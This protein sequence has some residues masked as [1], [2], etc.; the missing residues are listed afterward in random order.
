VKQVTTPSLSE[1][2]KRA[3]DNL[4]RG[5]TSQVTDYE[6]RF[7]I[8]KDAYDG[9]LV[10]LIRQ[11]FNPK[12]AWETAEEFF[13]KD[14]VRFAGVDGT[15]YS[16]P[17]FDLVIFFGGSYASTGT[18]TF[19]E[20][21]E[22]H[23]EYDSKT[24]GQN[25]G[26]SSV[27]PI[28]V[29]EI[30]D[31]DH[32]FAAQEQ[33]AEVD[34]SKPATDW[35]IASNSLIA[36]A[37]MTFSEFYLAYKL[38][39]DPT[40]NFRVLLMDR[41]LSTERASLL[42]ETRKTEF[43]DAKSALI[44][45]V[46]GGRQVDKNDLAIARQHVCNGQLGLPAPRAD[47]LRYAIINLAREKGTVTEVEV[48]E[49]F[50]IT[51]AKRLKRV[52]R[53]LAKLVKANVLTFDN[54]VYQLNERYVDCWERMRR[55]TVELGDQI[56]LSGSVDA[57]TSS[58]MKILKDGK[59]H[60]LTTLDVMLLTLYALQMLMD[61]CWRRHI[62]LVGITK[63]TS[64]RDFKRQ[65]VPIMQNE[66]LLAVAVQNE[67]FAALPNTDRM[68]L[69]S[70]SVFNPEKIVPPWS[71]IE[72]DSAFRT[73]KADSERGR[74]YICGLIRNKVG[75]E[76]AFLKTY[77]QLSQARSDP[78]LR[79]NVLL[80]DR[81]AYPEFDYKPEC[82]LALL[83]EMSDGTKEP[84]E[85]LLYKDKTVPNRMQ[86]MVMAMLV[87]MAPANIPEAF[88]HNK[89]LFVADK[90]AKWNYSQF[91]CVADSTAGWMMNNRKLRKF[92][93]YMSTF[94]ERRAGIEQARRENR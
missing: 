13:G 61:E 71:L 23:V 80:I 35:E 7:S 76:K 37:I 24:L 87:A 31:V 6:Q 27:V 28:Y 51:E 89:P 38:A 84:V 39:V 25:I 1:A 12:E 50:G 10:N 15:M 41:S 94:R 26:V 90:I 8:L 56:F 55:V 9:L 42:Y 92:I 82:R 81:L 43:W 93:F 16:R 47:Y 83:D 63:D 18:V 67:A 46:S 70:A 65:L 58:C 64:A 88:G 11:G 5:A 4:R 22:P 79:S 74:G 73:M 40:Q 72:Y 34:P 69:Q 49:A 17:M 29:N 60:W 52:N 36:N 30:P 53:S 86:N 32:S 68:I 91:K 3:C 77:V 44:G 45:Y 19:R 48:C 85:V 33:P 75:L 66:G 20:A 2:T 57:E 21:S 59:E 78:L 62:L 14:S 54:G